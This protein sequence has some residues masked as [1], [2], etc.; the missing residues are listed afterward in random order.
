M[1]FTVLGKSI[2]KQRPKFSRKGN[3]VTTYTPIKTVAY[4]KFVKLSALE[5]CNKELN[6]EYTGPVKMA[7]KAYFR[8]NKAISKKNYNSL[9]GKPYLKKSDA[10]NI[11]KIICDSLNGVAYKD[12]KQI[13]ILYVE[14]LYDDEERVEVKIEYEK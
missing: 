12:D 5:Q 4:E 6:K 11:A 14:K 3:Y 10:D 9:I 13:S 2:G 8:P 7:I 1:K